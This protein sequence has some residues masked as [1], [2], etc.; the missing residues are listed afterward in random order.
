[1]RHFWS[2]RFSR[3]IGFHGW[4]SHFW[5]REKILFLIEL[6]KSCGVIKILMQG[7]RSGYCSGLVKSLRHIVKS[8]PCCHIRSPLIV[9]IRTSPR[10]LLRTP[11]TPLLRAFSWMN[12]RA[13]FRIRRISSLRSPAL[14]SIL[15]LPTSLMLMIPSVVIELGIIIRFLIYILPNKVIGCKVTAII[16]SFFY[17]FVSV[18]TFQEV[19]LEAVIAIFPDAVT[20]DVLSSNWYVNWVFVIIIEMLVV[21]IASVVTGFFKHMFVVDVVH[22]LWKRF[23]GLFFVKKLKF[24]FYFLF[25][26]NFNFIKN[27]YLI[28]YN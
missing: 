9:I 2:S 26:E 16:V 6:I 21:K 28:L 8:I 4:S 3:T 14:H 11:F 22:F 17:L 20:W 23:F 13:P 15:L 25:M 1:M 27:G 7:L 24:K 18:L 12:P 10:P 5:V 19:F